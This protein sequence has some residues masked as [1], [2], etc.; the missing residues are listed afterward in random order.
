MGDS[1][2]QGAFKQPS[3]III[4]ETCTQK[5]RGYGRTFP[6]FFVQKE[7]RNPLDAGMGQWYYNTNKRNEVNAKT[8]AIRHLLII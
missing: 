7:A 6:R 5:K 8:N 2:R 3:T 1:K 4:A